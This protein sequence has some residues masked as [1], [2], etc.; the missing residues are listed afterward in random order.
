V[1]WFTK[2][3][4]VGWWHWLDLVFPYI[5]YMTFVVSRYMGKG[6]ESFS[7]VGA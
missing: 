5:V 6:Q 4:A 7:E 1:W 3:T 2:F